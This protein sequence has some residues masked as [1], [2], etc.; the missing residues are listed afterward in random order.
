[1][2]LAKAQRM[3]MERLGTGET[4]LLAILLDLPTTPDW[5]DGKDAAGRSVCLVGR[6]NLGTSEAAQAV[7]A[8][9]LEALAA[10]ELP[11]GVLAV[12]YAP[13]ASAFI[14]EVVDGSA[15]EVL[16]DGPRGS[17]K[18]QATP[19]ALAILAELHARAGFPLPL[20]VL[21][22]HDSLTNAALKTGQSLEQ[23]LW[24]G[25]WRLRD[26]RKEA[27]LTVAGVEMIV[28]VFVGTSDEVSSERLRAESHV[29]AAEEL[30][31]SLREFGGIEERKL[32]LGLT[33]MRLP[34]RRHV[35]LFTTNPGDEEHYV[36]QRFNI[37]GGG[38][39][40]RVRCQIPA[41]DRLTPDEV[42]AL[43]AAFR[44]SPDLEK[45]LA[46]GQWVALVIGEAVAVGFRS[47][48]HVAPHPLVPMPHV[49]LVMGHDAGLTPT[50]IIGQEVQGEI[51]VLVALASERAGTRQHLENLV[52]PWLA[53]HAPWA[54]QTRSLLISHYDSAMDTPDQSNVES[55]PV[56]V[57]REVLGGGTYPGAVSWP[58]R[59]DPLLSLLARL[60]PMTGR[61]KLQL[62]ADGC[63]LLISAL[64]SRWHYKKVN[65][66][67]SRDL[68]VKDHPASDL[69]D[70]LCYFVGGVAPEPIANTGPIPVETA[71][72]L[73]QQDHERM[74]MKGESRGDW[75]R[76]A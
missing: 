37:G 23:A 57:L 63:R 64:N 17:G 56:S 40:G 21:W 74:S 73:D 49:P 31:P 28:G 71:F 66:K 60:N 7:I 12:A 48:V 3:L 52:L 62:D 65:G 76:T 27:A 41:D 22:L 8:A 4:V 51:R 43:R 70:A 61:A 5:C 34:T 25:L 67:V 46:L 36:Y 69:G 1:M 38:R 20:R 29:L 58:G 13:K 39:P 53:I 50:T 11:D 55:S 42:A 33:S 32:E 35:G 6:H 30:V 19:A 45:R 47:E 10:G 18:T 75:I 59:R 54:M 2:S 68:P 9:V 14:A 15:R 44:D 26:D 72:S 24:G 16:A